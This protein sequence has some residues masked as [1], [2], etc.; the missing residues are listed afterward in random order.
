MKKF[1]ILKVTKIEHYIIPMI[2]DRRTEINGWKM[3][4]VVKDWFDHPMNRSHVTRDSHYIGNSSYVERVEIMDDIEK[5][6]KD[7]ELIRR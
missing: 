3:D 5:N 4:I 2:D 1:K 7:I 6:K